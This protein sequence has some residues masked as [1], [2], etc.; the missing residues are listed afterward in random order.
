MISWLK[1]RGGSSPADGRAIALQLWKGSS[2]RQR[3]ADSRQL[4]ATGGQPIWNGITCLAKWV[5]GVH[6]LALDTR[7]QYLGV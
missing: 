3:F 6:L 2:I 7:E 4:S 5:K 1:G